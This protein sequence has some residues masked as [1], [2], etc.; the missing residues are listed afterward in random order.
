MSCMTRLA[1][2]CQLDGW[3]RRTGATACLVLQFARARVILDHLRC[4]EGEDQEYRL[5]GCAASLRVRVGTVEQVT[6]L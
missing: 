4:A 3:V 5:E 6:W 1:G 2:A